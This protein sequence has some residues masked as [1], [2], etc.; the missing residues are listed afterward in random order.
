MP[1]VDAYDRVRPS[2]VA[3]VSRFG[4]SQADF[5]P[6]L[7]TGFF[8]SREG[9]VCTCRHVAEAIGQLSHPPGYQGF[10]AAVIGFREENDDDGAAWGTYVMEIQAIGAATLEP[11]GAQGYVGPNPPDVAYLKVN[12]RE[13]PALE[14]AEHS[15]REGEMVAFAGFPLGNQLLRAPGWL[16]QVCPT[17]HS[18]VVGAILPHRQHP[19][20]HGFLVHANTQGGASGS[21][22]FRKDGKLVGMLY[23]GVNEPRQ[24]SDGKA[25]YLVPT[26]LS[27]CVS[28]EIIAQSHVGAAAEAA[29]DQ[30][31]QSL[32]EYL[33]ALPRQKVMVGDG[34]LTPWTPPNDDKPGTTQP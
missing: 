20:P 3:I 26:S 25:V 24:T 18:G 34:V 1:F 6:I 5:P 7:G 32:E 30:A 23:M 22:V 4:L 19:T 27:G 16:H 17:M 9:V 2:L 28:R 33:Q 12:V 15:V 8:I 11:A 31:R 29:K 14:L 10:P 13:T 21:P